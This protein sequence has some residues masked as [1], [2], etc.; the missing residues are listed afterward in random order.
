MNESDGFPTIGNP[1]SQDKNAFS[2]LQMFQ[3]E[4]APCCGPPPDPPSSPLE[5]PGY[6]ICGFVDE[7]IETKAG[8][9]PKV[10]TKLDLYDWMGTLAS[11]FSGARND[12]KIAPGLYAA[13]RPDSQSQ[14]LVTANYKLTFDA[15][16]K[17][18]AGLNVWILVLD[19]RGVNVWCAAGKGH[20]GTDELVRRIRLSGL[21]DLVSHRRLIVPQLGATGV[22][23]ASVRKLSGFEV[24]WGPIRARDIKVFL[25]NGFKAEREMRTVTFTSWERAA[26]IPIEVTGLLK[27]S[28]ILIIVF[29]L[30]SGIGDD[31]FSMSA[32][33][34]RGWLALSGVIAGI[35]SGAVVAPLLLPW[36]PGT[37]FS[38]KGAFTGLAAGIALAVYYWAESGALELGALI[39]MVGALSSYLTMNF[40]G[41]T[42]FT[43]P[44]GV[45]KEMKSSIPVQAALSML[46]IVLWVYSG[47]IG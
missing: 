30:V 46:G 28:A 23:S 35:L 38:F 18:L 43:S 44:S 11:R 29:F 37:S 31:F 17:E 41:S 20:F 25:E 21:S 14:I 6:R 19:S 36:I 13:G 10:K 27:P 9:I 7:F 40:T 1:S 3:P 8:Y 15:L 45:E 4:D 26:L 12:Y 16:R 47:F 5:K 2:P 34:R 39:I 32:A 24:V 33:W 42:P 22:S